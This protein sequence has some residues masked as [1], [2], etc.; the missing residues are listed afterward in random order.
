MYKTLRDDG[1]LMKIDL[2]C[3]HTVN[4]ELG[5]RLVYNS[6]K[7]VWI[8]RG[9]YLG[10][11]PVWNGKTVT[12]D[13]MGTIKE[14]K[15]MQNLNEYNSNKLRARQNQTNKNGWERNGIACPKCG[16][17]LVDPNPHVK[18]MSNPP[19][20]NILCPKCNFTGYRVA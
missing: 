14:V 5:H 12:V 20:K 13:K 6:G 4:D 10:Q 11:K 18:L 8:R 17:E 19:Q 15:S 3:S 9:P 2:S 1:T 7:T 16:T